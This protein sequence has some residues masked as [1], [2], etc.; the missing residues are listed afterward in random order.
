MPVSVPCAR[1][2]A[3]SVGAAGGSPLFLVDRLSSPPRD[4]VTQGWIWVSFSH[5]LAW[6]STQASGSLTSHKRPP[7]TTVAVRLKGRSALRAPVVRRG[8]PDCGHATQRAESTHGPPLREQ[9]ASPLM[10]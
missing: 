5:S 9:F 6:H 8:Y 10:R 2:T 7:T 4:V 1:A 3:T